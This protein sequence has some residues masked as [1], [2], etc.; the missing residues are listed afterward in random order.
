MLIV[1]NVKTNY[2]DGPSFHYHTRLRPGLIYGLVGPSG[3]GKSTFLDVC[4]G[5]QP[6]YRGKITWQGRDIQDL[7]PYDRPVCYV[8]QSNN[9]VEHL[10]IT[11]HIIEWKKAII[12]KNQTRD[13]SSIDQKI[14]DFLEK[15]DLQH[16]TAQPVFSLSGGQKQRLSLLPL[17]IGNADIVLLD[18]PLTGL[19]P[20]QRRWMQGEIKAMKDPARLVIMT[21]HHMDEIMDVCDICLCMYKGQFIKTYNHQNI[22]D[23][24][25]DPF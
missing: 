3:C 20:V 13:I 1:N 7:M 8:S 21:S 12:R 18:E 14:Q 16:I 5:F 23:L 4:A 6:V 25:H 17:F 15:Y 2:D 9:V 24:H 19:S 10:T 22:D 11:Q